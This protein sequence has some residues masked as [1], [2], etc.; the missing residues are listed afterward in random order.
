MVGWVEKTSQP[1]PC[2]LLEANYKFY[3]EHAKDTTFSQKYLHRC[4]DC[5]PIT[6]KNW[7]QPKFIK[8]L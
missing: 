3:K 1:D 8:M 2:T 4:I 7:P 5:G 6:H